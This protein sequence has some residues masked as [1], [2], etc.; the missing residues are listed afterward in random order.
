M[1][2]PMKDVVDFGQ[3]PIESFP[4]KTALLEEMQT[5][6]YAYNQEDAALVLKTAITSDKNYWSMSGIN[7]THAKYLKDLASE[8]MGYLKIPL[9][10][11]DVVLDIGCNDG[12]LLHAYPDFLRRIGIDPARKI[13]ALGC[14]MHIREPFSAAIF[15][16]EGLEKAKIVTL[17]G[18]LQ[19]AQNPLQMLI[20]VEKILEDKGLVVVE[21]PYFPKL[22]ENRAFDAF[23]FEMKR[24]FTRQGF[25]KL[26]EKA[27][28]IVTRS[29]LIGENLRCFIEKKGVADTAA[30][31]PLGCL[32]TLKM[33]MDGV[34]NDLIAFLQQAKK[35][36]KSVMGYGASS[37]G[38]T[39]LSCCNIG[40]D[41]LPCIADRNP[42][43]WGR[44]TSTGI[45]IISEEEARSK[46]P[47]YFLVLPYRYIDTFMK[48][49][50][51][52]ILSGGKF[53]VPL[54]SLKE[55]P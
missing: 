52:F 49:E 10:E 48:R 42:I 8:A 32:E 36:K 18:V 19:S 30:D 17:I 33:Q 20:D 2:I 43:K 54:P 53:I 25:A 45:P 46:S 55:F 37:R 40:R 29:Q 24:L 27:G 15:E 14:D 1:I 50:H 26:V 9:N 6:S 23:N 21:F 39:L 7:E 22:I 34:K 47:D 5:L 31:L 3:L 13:R 4:R 11:D 16:E 12:T 35:E 28:L 51:A 38:N 44:F 41:L